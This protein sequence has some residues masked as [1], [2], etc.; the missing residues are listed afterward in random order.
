M[1]EYIFSVLRVLLGLIL[2]S[3]PY[4]LIPKSLWTLAGMRA[5]LLNLRRGSRFALGIINPWSSAHTKISEVARW[6]G[7]PDLS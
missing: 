6:L 4:R 1:K 2:E 5:I 3:L 7:V